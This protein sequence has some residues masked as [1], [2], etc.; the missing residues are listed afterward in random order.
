MA[1]EQAPAEQWAI[2]ELMGHVKLAGWV[3][4]DNTFGAALL[5][6]DVPD[7]PD[8]PGFTKCVSPSA[9][10]AVTPVSE[11]IA[12]GLAA[13]LQAKP[14]DTYELA[15]L[16][17]DRNLRLSFNSDRGLHDDPIEDDF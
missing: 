7:S 2:V 15:D 8:A 13:R 16:G 14:F 5:R 6:V 12:R 10:Y 11:Q 3:S 17:R 9:L 1:D 4:V